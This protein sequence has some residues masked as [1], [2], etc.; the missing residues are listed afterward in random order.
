MRR[1][2]ARTYFFSVIFGYFLG[3][4]MTMLVGVFFMSVAYIIEL[5]FRVDSNF[6]IMNTV[7]GAAMGALVGWLALVFERHFTRG[8][9]LKY[10][11]IRIFLCSMFGLYFGYFIRGILPFLPSDLVIPMGWEGSLLFPQFPAANVAWVLAIFMS[12]FV[13]N[14][15]LESQKFAITRE[16]RKK[17]NSFWSK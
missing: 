12:F 2:K 9:P 8:T 1:K 14:R 10:S 15:I 7:G 4:I 16:H 13:A 5:D 3:V 6:E 11:S 17:W